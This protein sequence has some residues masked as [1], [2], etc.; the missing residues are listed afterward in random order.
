MNPSRKPRAT[1]ERL[2]EIRRV[3][4]EAAQT[5][6]TQVDRATQSPASTSPAQTQQSYYGLPVLKKPV[7]TWQVPLYFF[8]GGIAG[9][10]VA[11][12]SRL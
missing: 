8:L 5:P 3:A 9:V 4:A 11:S 1:E 10:S 12:S 7:W 2:D 6:G